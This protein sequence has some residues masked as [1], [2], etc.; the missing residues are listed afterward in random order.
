MQKS[1]YIGLFDDVPRVVANGARGAA[2][3][4]TAGLIAEAMRRSRDRKEERL[5]AESAGESDENTIVLTLPRKSAADTAMPTAAGEPVKPRVPQQPMVSTSTST[6]RLGGGPK[7]QSRG[8][9]NGKFGP[10]YGGDV[11]KQASLLGTVGR[12]VLPWLG[13]NWGRAVKHRK[14]ILWGTGIAG[15]GGTAYG[16][17]RANAGYNPGMTPGTLAGSVLLGGATTVGGAAL[18]GKYFADKREREAKERVEL[19]R[20]EYLDRLSG[21]IKQGEEKTAGAFGTYLGVAELMALLGIGGTT[22]LTKKVL[23]EQLKE[24]DEKDLTIPKVKRI[25]F[26]TAPQDMT[27]REKMAEYVSDAERMNLAAGLMVMM[28]RV[29]GQY[30]FTSDPRVKCAMDV[31][32]VNAAALVKSA[33]NIDT[34]TAMLEKYAA[35]SDALYATHLDFVA[36]N[37]SWIT[38]G[39]Q[40]L[41]K[42]AQAAVGPTVPTPPIATPA[43]A[44]SGINWAEQARA[45]ADP[46]A[47]QAAIDQLKATGNYAKGLWN[48]GTA[49][50]NNGV[51]KVKDVAHTAYVGYKADQGFEK[52]KGVLNNIPQGLMA[53]A[54]MLGQLWTGI[55]GMMPHQ[56]SPGYARVMAGGAAPMPIESMGAPVPGV[57]GTPK[58]AS[59][60][61]SA[62]VGGVAG[63]RMLDDPGEKSPE[64]MADLIAEAQEKRIADK[65]EEAKLRKDKVS[66][67]ATDPAAAEYV[68]KNQKRIAA[69]VKR[70][71]AQ[72]QI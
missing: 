3:G 20:L 10:A 70:L 24:V 65:A 22:Y 67:G 2:V 57:G 50:V 36:R 62:L 44:G 15:T 7:G 13:R 12:K 60:G 32:G 56:Q 4:V 11:M 66:V 30:R 46:N 39:A 47:R 18:V 48:K 68:A 51:D 34:L 8:V 19:A 54:P 42:I 72:G 17:Y 14:G 31:S 23:D 29:A 71:A 9:D 33:E 21:G 16:L 63:L 49:A 26:R 45:M 6:L 64:E 37:T 41:V 69:L 55:K 25:V 40:N 38:P 61:L 35:V 28:D 43:T 5:K 52:M 59:A 1:A 27:E 53:A 58:I